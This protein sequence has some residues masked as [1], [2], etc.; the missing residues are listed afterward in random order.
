MNSSNQTNTLRLKPGRVLWVLSIGVVVVILLSLLGVHMRFFPQAYNVHTNNQA[1][2]I[3]DFSIE[4]N[5]NLQ[6]NVPTYFDMLL[7]SLAAYLLFMISKFKN[8]AKDKFRIIWSI[9]AWS[10]FLLA[11][12]NFTEILYSINYYFQTDEKSTPFPTTMVIMAG[13]IL[14]ILIALWKQFPDSSRWLLIGFGLTFVGA[15]IAKVYTHVYAAKNLHY[16]LYMI[17]EE[18]LKYTGELM[19]I[20]A[21][22]LYWQSVFSKIQISIKGTGNIVEIK[23]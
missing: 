21:L 8:K 1:N 12:D 16:A 17:L 9:M 4:T 18:A 23:S 6:H 15:S 7:M 3:E 11:L 2:F 14:L 5:L 19:L 22:L 20:H 13:V 10:V